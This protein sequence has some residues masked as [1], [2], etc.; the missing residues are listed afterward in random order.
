MPATTLPGGSVKAKESQ[1]KA[2]ERAKKELETQERLDNADL[3]ATIK[4]DGLDDIIY[5]PLRTVAKKLDEV[6]TNPDHEVLGRDIFNSFYKLQPKIV[7]EATPALSKIFED[8]FSLE[9]YK[10]IRGG[11]RFDDIASL[12]STIQ[13]APRIIEAYE[14]VQEKEKEENT[15]P[16]EE[17]KSLE[18]IYSDLSTDI[19]ISMRQ[20][21][22]E[23]EDMVDNW[24]DGLNGFG[25]EPG[26]K[27]QIDPASKL[28]LAELL[29]KDNELRQIL[30]L[31]GRF[32]NLAFA[33]VAKSYRHGAEEIVD[34]VQGSDLQ[35]LIP[36]E[37]MKLEVSELLFYKE[38]FEKQLL[39]Y[40][41]RGTEEVAKGPLVICLDRSSSM[42]GQ[43]DEWAKALSLAFIA[44][45]E[46]Q[47]RPVSVIMFDTR[48]QSEFKFTSKN[49]AT[50]KD[51][52]DI[53]GLAPSGG[54]NF[55][56]PLRRAYDIISSHQD[57]ECADIVMVTDGQYSF[58]HRESRWLSEAKE[59]YAPRI[60]GVLIDQGYGDL[61]HFCEETFLVNN[62]T[63]IKDVENLIQ[64]TAA[65]T[66]KKPN[67]GQHQEDQIMST[68]YARRRA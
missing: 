18:E 21:L 54:T 57:L 37:L 46:K 16:E 28:K 49:K 32:K 8:L 64:A 20:S 45:A 14:K 6:L 68:G 61:N 47:K 29:V 22:R 33:K 42:S 48:V 62:L 59:K 67:H 43:K 1:K 17:R 12:L 26:D 2:R 63:S 11:T 51:K 55:F 13:T 10:Q 31:A 40:E 39:N 65:G 25:I 36:S 53:A 7:D 66:Y 9:E 35:R 34:I 5:T 24:H 4:R 27:E 52:I 19:R 3:P 38:L 50:I 58:N 30:E 23:A 44:M 60:F 56:Q 41:M 15:K